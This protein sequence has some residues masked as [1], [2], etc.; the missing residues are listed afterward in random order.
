MKRTALIFTLLL[1]LSLACSLSG[2]ETP[3]TPQSEN[4]CGDGVCDGPEN[5]KTAQKIAHC[6]E[7]RKTILKMKKK[8]HQNPH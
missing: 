4:R 5:I 3:T 1:A 2:G 7:Y 8:M 6:Q